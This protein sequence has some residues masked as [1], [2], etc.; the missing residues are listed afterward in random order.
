MKIL[1]DETIERAIGHLQP[2]AEAIAGRIN[3]R[4]AALRM[5]EGEAG[6][7]NLF[8]DTKASGPA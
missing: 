3:S 4:W 5:I 8:A 7:L 1:Y 6:I 2:A